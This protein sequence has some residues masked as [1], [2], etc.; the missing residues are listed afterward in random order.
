MW[1]HLK[2]KNFCLV[3]NSLDRHKW[4][5]L[6][7]NVCVS[8]QIVNSTCSWSHPFKRI[9]PRHLL[10]CMQ[11]CKFPMASK[12]LSKWA[13][14]FYKGSLQLTDLGAR[15]KLRKHPPAWTHDSPN[16]FGS[17]HSTWYKPP[18]IR[19][20]GEYANDVRTFGEYANVFANTV[21]K[22]GEKYQR[23]DVVFDR[24]QEESIKTGTRIKWKQCPIHRKI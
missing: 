22:M 11:L 18:D 3:Q 1:S 10:L 17:L 13:R 15:Y 19:T 24:Y 7:T 14:T 16:I 8:L 6:C 9:R 2:F 12:S 5:P 20:F 21:L 4:K 23:I